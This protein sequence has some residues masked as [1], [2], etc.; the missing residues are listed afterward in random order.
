MYVNIVQSGNTE[1]KSVSAQ[2][3][4]TPKDMQVGKGWNRN[5]QQN[6]SRKIRKN[7]SYAS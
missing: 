7:I 6:D 2:G 1:K 5:G 4:Q 3:A